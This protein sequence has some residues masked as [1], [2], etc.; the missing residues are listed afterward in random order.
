MD[1]K[2]SIILSTYNEAKVIENTIN[3]IFKHVKDAEIIV[4]DD[5]S[6]DGTLEIVKKIKSPNLKIFSKKTRGL[7]AALLTGLINSSGDVI[8]W[9]DS[10]RPSLVSKLPDMIS[11]L[12]YYDIITTGVAIL[13][14]DDSTYILEKITSEPV[15]LQ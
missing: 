8:G 2:I 6:P 14:A 13:S 9:I 7:A 10:N 15:V 4:V 1:K 12:D 5:N 11:K 3:E